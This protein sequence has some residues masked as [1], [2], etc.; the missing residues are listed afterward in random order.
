MM[1][2]RPGERLGAA[3]CVKVQLLLGVTLSQI[4]VSLNRQISKQESF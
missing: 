1:C 2:E 4:S 3:Q